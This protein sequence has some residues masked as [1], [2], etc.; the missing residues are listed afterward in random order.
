MYAR[1]IAGRDFLGAYGSTGLDG[2]RKAQ[3][4]AVADLWVDQFFVDWDRAL[5]S[6]DAV[7]PDV[8]RAALMVGSAEYIM[9]SFSASNPGSVEPDFARSLRLNAEAIAKESKA[10]GWVMASDRCR[11][12]STEGDRSS[13][14]VRCVR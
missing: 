2:D 1:L 14:N 11:Q 4:E 6:E 13:M 12:L 10:R 5:W 9:R 3:S 8:K 7:P